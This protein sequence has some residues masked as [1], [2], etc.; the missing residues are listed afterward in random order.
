MESRI[1]IEIRDS[2]LPVWPKKSCGLLVIV[3]E[4][5]AESFFAAHATFSLADDFLISRKEQDIAF[6]LVVPLF[7]EVYCVLADCSA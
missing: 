6:A 3:F 1:F 5:S 7:M 4:E 2:V